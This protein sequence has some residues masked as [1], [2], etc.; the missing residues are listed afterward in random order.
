M[1]SAAI[2]ILSRVYPVRVCPGLLSAVPAGLKPEPAVLTQTLKA[3]PPQPFSARLKPCSLSPNPLTLTG[4]N[5]S[6]PG[7]HAMLLRSPSTHVVLSLR[8]I[9]NAGRKRIFR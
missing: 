7:L 5:D 4:R 8:G 3:V 1:F 6:S 9:D 2:R